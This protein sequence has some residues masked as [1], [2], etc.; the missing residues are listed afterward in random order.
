[1]LWRFRSPLIWIAV[2]LEEATAEA[3]AAG[4]SAV[5]AAPGC[6]SMTLSKVRA[7]AAGILLPPSQCLMAS[8]RVKESGWCRTS[9]SRIAF[10]ANLL[11]CALNLSCSPARKAATLLRPSVICSNWVF[12]P[13][14]VGLENAFGPP[15]PGF[16][17]HSLEK[18]WLGKCRKPRSGTLVE[19]GRCLDTKVIG[20]V[21][22]AVPAV[23]IVS[24]I[25][26]ETAESEG[27]RLQRMPPPKIQNVPRLR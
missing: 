22:A 18:R 16:P 3:N 15:S 20:A 27:G 25:P 14:P 11:G 17:F 24:A 5:S 23:R 2:R 26:S 13:T 1:M 8:R 4:F 21:Q 7:G 12:M 9:R 19:P 10:T 6:L